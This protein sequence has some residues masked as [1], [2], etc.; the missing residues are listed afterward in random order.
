VSWIKGFDFVFIHC[1]RNKGKI[2]SVDWID[3]DGSSIQTISSIDFKDQ[4]PYPTGVLRVK[5][6]DIGND[7]SDRLFKVTSVAVDKFLGIA[8]SQFSPNGKYLAV[9]RQS[10]NVVELW[11]L[12]DSERTHRFTYPL[13]NI[14]SLHFLPTSD[15][16]T[17]VFEK[18]HKCL[19]R[20]DTQDMTSFNL[21]VEDIPLA[22]IH[23]PNANYLF[24]P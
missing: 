14:S 9:G 7:R 21:D 6:W 19:W 23:L 22:I 15:C 17:A 16:L 4:G 18:S 20:L 2:A 12:E 3:E 24:V 5:L 10:E 1:G 13:D 8:I 11:N